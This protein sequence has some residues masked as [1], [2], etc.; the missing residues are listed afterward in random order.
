[1]FFININEINVL[2]KKNKLLKILN[3]IYEVNLT[4]NAPWKVLERCKECVVALT[5]K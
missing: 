1:M 4:N 2:N 3:E 5:D